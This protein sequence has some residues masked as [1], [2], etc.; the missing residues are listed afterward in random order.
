MV[1]VSG[2]AGLSAGEGCAVD[3]CVESL[4]PA[5]LPQPRSALSL[6]LA[7]SLR[8]P[9]LVLRACPGPSRAPYPLNHRSLLGLHVVSTWDPLFSQSLGLAMSA[10]E[11][12]A[13]SCLRSGLGAGPVVVVVGGRVGSV[14]LSG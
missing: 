10:S 13:P 8:L 3:M 12:L 9:S 5:H 7:P 14:W 4:T 11:P 2:A 1:S 6:M